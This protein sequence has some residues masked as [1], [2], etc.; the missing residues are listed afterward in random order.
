[1]L[2]AYVISIASPSSHYFFRAAAARRWRLR[3]PRPQE[4][5]NFETRR[6][7]V[8]AIMGGY[9]TLSLSLCGSLDGLLAR[10]LSPSVCG[11]W[12]KRGEGNWREVRWSVRPSASVRPPPSVRLRPEIRLPDAIFVSIS[13]IQIDTARHAQ[14]SSGQGPAGRTL[15][16]I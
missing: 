16:A 9:V 11:D 6:G 10:Q 3:R 12:G 7:E 15:A 5:A 2:T 13:S 14:T 8:T 4:K 1:M